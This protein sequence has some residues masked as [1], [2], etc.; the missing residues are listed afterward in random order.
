MHYVRALKLLHSAKPKASEFIF[1]GVNSN[2]AGWWYLLH[3]SNLNSVNF[4]CKIQNKASIK[5]STRNQTNRSNMCYEMKETQTSSQAVW[6]CQVMLLNLALWE[7]SSK[8]Q[9]PRTIGFQQSVVGRIK[10]S[11]QQDTEGQPTAILQHK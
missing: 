4:L 7:K 8:T 11:S 1:I 2:L 6:L 9:P 5:F 3:T 10:G